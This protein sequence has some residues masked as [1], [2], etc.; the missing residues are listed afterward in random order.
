MIKTKL[1]ILLFLLTSCGFKPV[2]STNNTFIPV[3]TTTITSSEPKESKLNFMMK[4]ALKEALNP[5]NV[6]FEKKYDMSIVIKK[7]ILSFETL[8]TSV[9]TRNRISLSA[10]Y[11]V[12][13]LNGNTVLKDKVEACDSFAIA[14]S[15]Y[16]EVVSEEEITIL[17]AR[18]LAQQIALKLRVFIN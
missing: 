11:K 9:N 2:Y 6:A 1:I 12:I 10:H 16:S 13:D 18:V 7:D 4:Q 5:L 17:L 14:I 8:N 3:N 15:P